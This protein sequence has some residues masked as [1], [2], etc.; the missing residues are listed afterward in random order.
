MSGI[1]AG[2]LEP[3]PKATG[4][5]E[6]PKATDTEQSFPKESLPVKQERRVS[7]SR[8]TPPSVPAI[9]DRPIQG[10]G[11]SE[12]LPKERERTPRNVE[13][14]LAKRGDDLQLHVEN[15][16]MKE[17]I[18]HHLYEG[19]TLR[20]EGNKL[21]LPLGDLPVVIVKRDIHLYLHQKKETYSNFSQSF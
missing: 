10:R 13:S 17:G 9:E 20:K 4:S 1:M 18:D 6:Q 3:S 11:P 8:P 21:H 2:I 14:P 5:Q 12:E 16:L 15:T 7:P 19:I